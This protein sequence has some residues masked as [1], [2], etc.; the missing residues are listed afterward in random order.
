MLVI[1]YNFI[2]IMSSIENILFVSLALL[3]INYINMNMMTN[4]N[5]MTNMILLIFS[6]SQQNTAT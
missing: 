5:I 1:Q 3:F 6:L 2:P 4:K